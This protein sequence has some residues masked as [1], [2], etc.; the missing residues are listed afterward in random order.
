M[1]LKAAGVKDLYEIEAFARMLFPEIKLSENLP[2]KDFVSVAI[3]RLPLGA[4]LSA[5]IS[6][7]GKEQREEKFVEKYEESDGDLTRTLALL[8]NLCYYRL[9]GEAPSWGILTGIRPIK[10]YRE[11]LKENKS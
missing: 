4:K 1:I 3:E 11:L 8:L 2:Q 9:M 10:F 6:F 7:N 5:V